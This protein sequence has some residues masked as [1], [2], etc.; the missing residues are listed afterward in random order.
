MKKVFICSRYRPDERHT[1][2][3]AVNSAL[4]ACSVA[5]Q[6]GYAP[7]APHLYV[8]N[9]LNDDDPGDRTKGMEIGM[10]FLKACDEVWRW[11]FTV[12]DG[13][14][15]ELDYAEKLGKPIKVFNTIGIPY[16]QWNSVRFAGKLSD[17]ELA[18]LEWV[19]RTN[20]MASYYAKWGNEN[21]GFQTEGAITV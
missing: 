3:E 17:E 11:G 6:H 8:P 1:V 21:S 13:M 9:C 16:E 7:Y 14:R 12:T 10:E 19:E 2:E 4:L 5:I 18:D 20:D 15:S